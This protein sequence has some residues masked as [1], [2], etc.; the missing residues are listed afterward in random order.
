MHPIACLRLQGAGGTVPTSLL[1]HMVDKR[2]AFLLQTHRTERWYMSIGRWDKRMGRCLDCRQEYFKEAM[3]E[4]DC[5]P[6]VL[7]SPRRFNNLCFTGQP[8]QP[9][10]PLLLVSVSILLSGVQTLPSWT[11]RLRDSL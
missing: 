10:A 5:F 1:L 4:I 8:A 6:T 7:S 3:V 11:M 2:Y 9:L